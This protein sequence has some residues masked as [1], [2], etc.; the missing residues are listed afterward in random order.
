MIKQ[1]S[2]KIFSGPTGNKSVRKSCIQIP[3]ADVAIFSAREKIYSGVSVSNSSLSSLIKSNRWLF[4]SALWKGS[5]KWSGQPQKKQGLMESQKVPET[6]STNRA[7]AQ[8]ALNLHFP[9][10][11]T[12]DSPYAP[13]ANVNVTKARGVCTEA[14]RRCL[15]CFFILQS[16]GASCWGLESVAGSG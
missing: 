13:A 14:W 11:I 12:T 16:K 10:I 8:G 6:S 4:S 9:P 3:G 15:V 7:Y 2:C 1:L 5:T